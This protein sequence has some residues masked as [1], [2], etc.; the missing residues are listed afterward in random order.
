ME[1]NKKILEKLLLDIDILNELDKWTKDINFF[2]ISGMANREIKHSE[3]LSWFLDANENHNLKDQFIRR[4]LQKVITRNV[5]VIKGLDIFDVSALDYST[6]T[7]KREWKYIDLVIY[8][9][10]LKTVIAIE[11]KVY[12]SESKGQLPKYYEVIKKE[13]N[14]FDKFMFIFL[15]REGEEPSDP[16][17]WCIADYR[18]IIDA[19]EETINSNVMI[20]NKTE[21]IIKDYVSMIRRNFGMDN[22]LKRTVQKIYLQ[23]KKAF[24]LIFEIASTSHIQFSEYIKSWLEENKDKYKLAFDEKYS[25]NT[26]IRFTSEYIDELFPF[27]DEKGDDWKYGYSFM[28]EFKIRKDSIHLMGVLANL[29]R[30]NSKY[31]MEVGKNVSK[32][33]KWRIVLPAKLI[34]SEENIADGLTPEVIKTLDKALAKSIEKYVVNFEK[35]IKEVIEQNI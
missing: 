17:N 33:T 3:T 12:A 29:Q 30:P 23:H 31:L 34:L 9:N 4:F 27:D 10:E 1:D 11:N 28:Y 26:I 15:T 7:V 13:F 6:F 20:S 8:S 25:T 32:A 14:D 2:E 22:E 35:E 19:L 16:E 18:M 24:D 5:D 21:M